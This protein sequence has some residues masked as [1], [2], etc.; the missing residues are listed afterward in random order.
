MVFQ[1]INI[2]Q[3]RRKVEAAASGRGFQHL[4]RDLAKVNAWK[5]MFDP[6]IN[7]CLYSIMYRLIFRSMRDYIIQND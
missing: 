3:D 2:R 1:C 6:Y 5:S 4:P 7:M